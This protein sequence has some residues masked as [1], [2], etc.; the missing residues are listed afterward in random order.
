MLY[1]KDGMK[2]NDI[3]IMYGIN[4]GTVSKIVNNKL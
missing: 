2:Q 3:A 4:Q 1:Y